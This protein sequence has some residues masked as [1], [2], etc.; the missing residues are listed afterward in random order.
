MA[1]PL[2]S[3]TTPR[4]LIRYAIYSATPRRSL[5]TAQTT[6]PPPPAAA[7]EAAQQLQQA[8]QNHII[9]R[10]QALDAHHL[11]KLS[12]TLN[13]PY[14]HLHPRTQDITTTP[15]QIGTPLPPGYHL[16]YFSPAALEAD[17]A[18]DGTDTTFN[19]PAPFSR[20]MVGLFPSPFVTP[21]DQTSTSLS[22]LLLH[23]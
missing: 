9:T 7:A 22:F 18:P 6:T 10:D 13:R 8:F 1:S 12:L 17:L 19:A 14:L 4:L 2:R 15:P 21:R 3:S 11:Q 23:G 5:K 16:A 20:R